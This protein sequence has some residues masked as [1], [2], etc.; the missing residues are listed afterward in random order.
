VSLKLAQ[1]GIDIATNGQDMRVWIER[2]YLGHTTQAAGA[3]TEVV[4]WL[5]PLFVRHEYIVYIFARAHNDKTQINRLDGG[6]IFQAMYSYINTLLMKSTF[7]L[8]HK[9]PIATNL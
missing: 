6:K 2:A 3:D 8:C 5:Q 1:A 7:N 9:N 4:A